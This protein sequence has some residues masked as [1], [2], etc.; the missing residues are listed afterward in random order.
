MKI[1]VLLFLTLLSVRASNI[2]GGD[3]FSDGSEIVLI[4]PINILP[5]GGFFPVRV[6]MINKGIAERSWSLSFGSIVNSYYYRGSRNSEAEEI[7][8][9]F[10][11]TCPP[12]LTRTVE[13]LVPVHQRIDPWSGERRVRVNMSRGDGES[14]YDVF[15]LEPSF[16]AHLG[17]SG[18][19]LTR[20]EAEISN[21]WMGITEEN[22]R[23]TRRRYSSSIITVAGGVDAKKLPS[24]WRAYAGYDTLVLSRQD[25]LVLEPGA[26]A[27]IE[28]WVSGGG[29][30]VVLKDGENALL[31]GFEEDHVSQ[32]FGHKSLLQCGENYAD[33]KALDL[34]ILLSN[35]GPSQVEQAT[36]HYNVNIWGIGR[37][38]GVRSLG[39]TFIL[40][41]LIVFA[42]IVGPVNLFFWANKNQRQRLLWTTPLISL[43]ASLLLVGFIMLKDGF[44][45]EG[46]RAIAI[47]VG[48]PDDNYA[49]LIQEQFSRTGILL[50]SD[51]SFD[52]DS[53][54]IPVPAPAT[55]FN[56]I[57]SA[58]SY[59]VFS[60]AIQPSDEGWSV[61]GD[62][63][64]SRAERAQIL[65]SVTPS[66][67]RLE[68]LPRTG[69]APQLVSSFSYPLTDIFFRDQDD[70]V[71]TAS[72]IA[73]GATVTMTRSSAEAQAARLS[74]TIERFGEAHGQTLQV[75]TERPGS[76]SA[77][78]ENAPALETHTSIDWQD[79]PALITGLLIK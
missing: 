46:A 16:D 74:P 49:A 30:L 33:F 21:A 2:F 45:G 60:A 23:S 68:F 40:I 25:Y 53:V 79:S 7:I 56:R 14:N 54:F 58:A 5:A 12:N 32:G 39:T 57:G 20:F 59:G 18:D 66:R 43:I 63:F 27:A 29:N 64:Q 77:L 47:D 11:V 36:R 15:E 6:E 44:G 61:E 50:N 67:E 51:F 26:K 31:P 13:L 76:F 1:L 35:T 78:A 71:W 24:D 9:N 19:L 70:K 52:K 3:S 73:S 28:K 75:L 41:A 22:A 42:I 37:E 17:M 34:K 48:G 38:L 72:S 65:R 10:T 62:F 55:D 4:A 69:V 8:S